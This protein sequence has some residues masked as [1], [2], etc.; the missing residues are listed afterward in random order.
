MAEG[1]GLQEIRI[2]FYFLIS[3]FELCHECF[4]ILLG[5]LIGKNVIGTYASIFSREFH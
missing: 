4:Y 1:L 5:V 2:D 3:F